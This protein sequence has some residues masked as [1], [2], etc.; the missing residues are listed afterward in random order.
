MTALATALAL[1]LALIPVA[2][3][4]E[5]PQLDTVM[6]RLDRIARGV[7]KPAPREPEGMPYALQIRAAALRSGLSPS[8]LAALV[9]QESA[10]DR[11]AIS[12][13][14]A[15]GLGQLMPA[16]ARSLGVTDPFDAIQ[17]LDGA[18]RYL[19][20]QLDRFGSVRLALGAYHAGPQRISLGL[21]AAPASTRDYVRRVL[22]FERQYRDERLP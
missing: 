7:W 8:L 22:R 13:K 15:M 20:R 19:A 4:A 10:F 5:R 2:A 6:A 9:R 18:A 14:G 1:V 17:N 12:H 11:F 21:A 3:R 16:T